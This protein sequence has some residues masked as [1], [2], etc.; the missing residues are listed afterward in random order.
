MKRLMVLFLTFSLLIFGIPS[1]AFALQQKL[2][3][4]SYKFYPLR[5]TV[6]VDFHNPHFAPIDNI[7]VNMVIREGTGR[8]RVVAIG[9]TFLPP[10]LTLAPG[11]HAST[12]VPIRAR[13][14][15]DIP[16]L[17]QFEFHITGRQLENGQAPPDVVVQGSANGAQLE[18]NRD[19]NGVPMVLGFIQLNPTITTEATVDVQA[20]ILTFYDSEHR[21]V[22]SETMPIGARLTSNESRMIWGKY[23]Q[24]NLQLVPDL[25]QIDVKFVTGASQ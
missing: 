16:A 9:Q 5:D 12:M 21:V 18:F 24:I 19:P 7:V 25:A 14:L 23:E 6:F 11:E 8:N 15:R 2:P 13:V 1:E 22:W 10:A 17:A 3:E 20:A 4:L